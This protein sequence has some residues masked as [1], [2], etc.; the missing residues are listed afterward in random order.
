MRLSLRWRIV[1]TLFPLFLLL[2]V[3]GTAGALLLYHLSGRIEA[4]L[5]ENYRSVIYME[6]LDE[7]L[8][9][10]DSSFQFALAGREDQA[11]KLYAASWPKLRDSL[12]LE[13]DNITLP[14]EQE[15]VDRLAYLI[16]RY[17][18]HGQTFYQRP[19][20]GPQRQQDYFQ[21]DD[22]PGVLQALFLEMR[23]SA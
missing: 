9:R 20:G 22:T 7:A 17:R 15:L 4:M 16:E 8:E 13:Q 14:G 21:P 11:R 1:L 5:Q 3:L 19:P 10:M 23:R 12:R 6:R 2:V 18:Q